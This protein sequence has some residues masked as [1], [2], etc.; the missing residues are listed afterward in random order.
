MPD[1][2]EKLEKKIAFLERRL[3]LYEKAASARL[4]YALIR[5]Q[6]EMAD[7]LNENYLKTA[8]AESDKSFERLR[9]LWND[10][11][12]VVIDTKIL[13]EALGITGDEIRDTARNTTF[14]D[15]NAT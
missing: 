13:G 10:A 9:S 4:Y 8:I 2:V 1:E 6:N 15:Q 12:D 14:L 7:L 5:K 11:K 3:D